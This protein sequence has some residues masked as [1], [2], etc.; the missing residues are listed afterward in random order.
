MP[1]APRTSIKQLDAEQFIRE[2][3]KAAGMTTAEF[4]AAYSGMTPEQ[5]KPRTF[6][7]AIRAA[8]EAM[9]SDPPLIV[10]ESA[11]DPRDAEIARLR[12]ELKR[13]SEDRDAYAALANWLTRELAEAWEEMARER[14]KNFLEGESK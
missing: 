7:D 6:D 12:A 2:A 13:S 9:D 1:D 4:A 5:I 11:P 10:P 14:A 3:A 8:H